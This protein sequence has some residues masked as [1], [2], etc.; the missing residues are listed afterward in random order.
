MCNGV[1][2]P[3]CVSREEG[4]EDLLKEN[5]LPYGWGRVQGVLLLISGLGRLTKPAENGIGSA[6][7]VALNMLLGVCI[8]RRNKLL[9]PLIAIVLGVPPSQ[10]Y[11]RGADPR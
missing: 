6:F 2:C 10:Y 1:L 8:L 4:R 5:D 11:Y 3:A 7:E 9:L